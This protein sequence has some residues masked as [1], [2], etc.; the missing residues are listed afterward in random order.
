MNK[1]ILETIEF[2]VPTPNKSLEDYIKEGNASAIHHLARYTWV[3]TLLPATGR[4]L[5]IAC[6]AGYG[7]YLLA[8]ANP[9]LEVIGVDYDLRAIEFAKSNYVASNLCFFKGDLVEWTFEDGSQLGSYDVIV[10][11]DTIE[12]LLHREVAL[13]N[14]AQNL[15]SNGLLI[16]STPSGHT[17]PLLNPGWEH[18][19]IE[20][21]G[22][23]LLNLI[24]RFFGEVLFPDNGS[25]PNLAFWLALNENKNIYWNRMNPLVCTKPIKFSDI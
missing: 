13:I 15:H 8:T 25:L 24:R 20:Y 18:H 10:C 12:H 14:L 11:F 6:G 16:F 7:S 9:A 1:D 22:N 19:K 23:L 17:K 2:F 21:S 3:Q 5:D 4:V